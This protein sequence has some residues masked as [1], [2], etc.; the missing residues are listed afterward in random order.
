M[1]VLHGSAHRG[2]TGYARKVILQGYQA[3][4]VVEYPAREVFQRWVAG[5]N[6]A[7][8]KAALLHTG[9]QTNKDGFIDEVSIA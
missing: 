9:K 6:P 8:D 5:N 3:V 2:L 4:E 1:R 7:E